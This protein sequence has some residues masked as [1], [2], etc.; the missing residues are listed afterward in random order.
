MIFVLMTIYILL[1]KLWY[2]VS[3]I[4]FGIHKVVLFIYPNGVK[5]LIDNLTIN[6]QKRIMSKL[7]PMIA[8]P[9]FKTLFS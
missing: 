3:L 8:T 5:R 2:K 1:P 7:R 6:T 4:N 9:P